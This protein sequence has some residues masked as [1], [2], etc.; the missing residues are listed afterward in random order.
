MGKTQQQHNLTIVQKTLEF[1][2][3]IKVLESGGRAEEAQNA[4]FLKSSVESLQSVMI[5][6][7]MSSSGVGPLFLLSLVSNQPP[8]KIF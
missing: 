4:S 8:T 7:A 1:H 6:G 5:W 3:E 2:L